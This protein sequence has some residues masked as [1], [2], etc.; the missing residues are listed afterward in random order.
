MR[1]GEHKPED[2]MRRKGAIE[3]KTSESG[4]CLARNG[5]ETKEL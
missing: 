1:G 2:K 4:R 3:R 5:G